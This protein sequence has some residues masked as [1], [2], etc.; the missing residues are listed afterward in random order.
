LKLFFVA[1]ALFTGVFL[2][3]VVLLP[4]IIASPGGAAD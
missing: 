2:F 4:L 1:T 3:L